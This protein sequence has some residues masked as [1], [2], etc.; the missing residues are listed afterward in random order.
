MPCGS[1]PAIV[2]PRARVGSACDIEPVGRR[3][4]PRRLRSRPRVAARSGSM[5]AAAPARGERGVGG[6]AA[7]DRRV[8]ARRA[9]VHASASVNADGVA[10][11]IGEPAPQAS[12]RRAQLVVEA[13]PAGVPAVGAPRR[14]VST[15]R[16]TTSARTTSSGVRAGRAA[17]AAPG[18]ELSRAASTVRAPRSRAIEVVARHV[19]AQRPG[20]R[21]R[22][23]AVTGGAAPR[24]TVAAR[25]ARPA[26]SAPRGGWSHCV[27]H[28]AHARPRHAA[29]A[30]RSRT[31]RSRDA[32]SRCRARTARS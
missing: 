3:R 17:T 30:A 12:R 28:C 24:L 13:D 6:D 20:E 8:R 29:R 10:E 16:T 27:Y 26:G 31:A 5:R 15:P 32:S 22:A 7:V 19:V 2:A 21:E 18:V 14:S 1:E 11:R 9:S 4:G 23:G 25:T